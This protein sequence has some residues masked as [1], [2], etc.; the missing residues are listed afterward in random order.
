MV[1]LSYPLKAWFFA[2][3]LTKPR[4]AV[5][6]YYAQVNKNMIQNYLV[7]NEHKTFSARVQYVAW[8]LCAVRGGY[9]WIDVFG[10]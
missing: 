10:C 8:N 6:R 2:T 4:E 9:V 5:A 3:A 7:P 1:S